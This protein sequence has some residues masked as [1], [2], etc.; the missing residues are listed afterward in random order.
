MASTVN[1]PDDDDMADVRRV[2]AGDVEA[3][4]GIVR[5]WQERLVNLAWRFCRDR[6]MA[7]EMAQ[8]AFVKAFR[9]LP[10]FRGDAAVATWLTAIA[11]NSYRSALRLRPPAALPLDR[12]AVA[13]AAATGPTALEGLLD[14]ERAEAVRRLVLTLPRRYRE[15]LVLFYFEERDLAATAAALGLPQG[16]VK[17]RL[18]RGRALL[19]RRCAALFPGGSGTDA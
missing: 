14:Q 5:R 8:E 4:G 15:P 13:G 3:F 9:S 10:T 17:A 1:R 12:L 18:A 6:M 16:T 7:E 2:L 19:A 11:L